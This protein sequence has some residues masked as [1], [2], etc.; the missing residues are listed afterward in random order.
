MSAK[1]SILKN[2]LTSPTQKLVISG[3]CVQDRHHQLAAILGSAVDA[4]L[5]RVFCVPIACDQSSG[6]TDTAKDTWLVDQVN[7][8]KLCSLTELRGL[9]ERRSAS[10][11]LR[12]HIQAIQKLIANYERSITNDIRAV[13]SL[14]RLVMYVPSEDCVLYDGDELRIIQWGEAQFGSALDDTPLLQ[15]MA[16]RPLPALPRARRVQSAA[17][18]FINYIGSINRDNAKK[19]AKLKRKAGA[20]TG[21]LT[22]TLMWNT[23]DDLDIHV[24]CPDGTNINYSNRS[25]CGGKLD[26]DMNVSDPKLD[27]I[28]NIFWAKHPPVGTYKV[29]VDNFYNRSNLK[30]GTPFQV[31]IDYASNIQK[32]TGMVS[33]KHG[34]LP[35]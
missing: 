2:S 7:T 17:V 18:K 33:T 35:V 15:T 21:L 8:N 34:L 25:S 24:A 28:E 26:V 16:S 22:I 32:M 5:A 3:V 9:S 1:Q 11:S 23:L 4:H 13:Q 14:L 19:L 12:N 31:F 10:I 29:Y 6:G 20:K 27:P 30:G